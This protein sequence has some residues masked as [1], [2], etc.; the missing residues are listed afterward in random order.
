VRIT[1]RSQ[2]FNF[3][4]SEFSRN[5]D[6][7]EVWRRVLKM[8]LFGNFF[9]NWIDADDL[10]RVNAAAVFTQPPTS[11]TPVSCRSLILNSS[12]GPVKNSAGR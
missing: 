7:S 11:G 2:L 10:W 8:A 5:L 1:L 12:E 9:G 6:S 4:F 3:D